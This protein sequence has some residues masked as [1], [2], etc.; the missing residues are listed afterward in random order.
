MQLLSVKSRLKGGQ[1][2]VM[3]KKDDA[4]K[5]GLRWK[6]SEKTTDKWRGPTQVQMLYVLQHLRLIIFF[7]TLSTAFFTASGLLAVTYACKGS[8][9][10]GSGCPSLRPTFPSFTDPFPRIIILAPV[11]LSI[12]E[13]NID[14]QR[15]L[16][17]KLPTIC[18]KDSDIIILLHR[19]SVEHLPP[20]TS[21]FTVLLRFCAKR[22]TSVLFTF[23]HSSSCF[24]AEKDNKI[25]NFLNSLLL[26]FAL[27]TCLSGK[28]LG[29]GEGLTTLLVESTV[30]TKQC[31]QE[32]P[33][34]TKTK[35]KS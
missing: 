21:T 10:P 22:Y 35:I 5:L 6:N 33:L 20:P 13:I 24:H 11:S 14:C 9:S 31:L 8:S 28:R 27:F 32:R 7:L 30:Q 25:L 23:I 19:S 18:H 29:G 15:S 26:F 12:A 1:K 34:H 3:Q 16:S 2:Y 4:R 17:T